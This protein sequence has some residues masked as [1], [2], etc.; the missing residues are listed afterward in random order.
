[1]HLY[2]R[3]ALEC[4]KLLFNNPFLADKMEY[5]PYKLFTSAERD[6]RVYTEWMSSDGAWELQVSIESIIL[7]ILAN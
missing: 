6:V 7:I 3:D 4:V 1:M 5:A 2:F